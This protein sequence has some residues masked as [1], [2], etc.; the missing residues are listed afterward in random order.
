MSTSNRLSKIKALLKKKAPNHR[1][2]RPVFW[3]PAGLIQRITPIKLIQNWLSTK[4]SLTAKLRQLDP[5]LEVIVL[6]EKLEQPMVNEAQSLGLPPQEPTWVRCVLLK[7]GGK[8]WVYA[9]T[10]IPHF[11]E[12][13]PWV[14]L[15]NLGNQPLGEILFQDSS[16]QRTPFTFSNPPL[17][18]WPY[19]SSQITIERYP[20]KGYARRSV[21]TQQQAPLLLTE[22]FL[23]CLLEDITRSADNE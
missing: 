9:R 13:N 10:V 16:I 15:Q 11:S 7:G 6:S 22:V 5:K 19:L 20:E 8:N 12:T 3:K 17:D 23:P 18:T 14:H 1:A 4:D 2:L 21:F